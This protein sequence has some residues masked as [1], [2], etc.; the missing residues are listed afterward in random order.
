MTERL[1][2]FTPGDLT[3]E[4]RALYDTI[5]GGPRGQGRQV[6]PLTDDE[7]ALAGPFNAMLLH[8]P[9]GSALQALGSAVRYQGVLDDRAREIAILVVARHWRSGFERY[10][11]EAIGA[12]IGLSDT[13]LAALRA[14]EAF[15]DEHDRLVAAT[16][17]A[18]AARG[19]LSDAEFTAARD[20]LGSAAVF[21]LTTLVGYYAMLAMQ[22]RV[23]QVDAPA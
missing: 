1:A 7:G 3:G 14:G 12:S 22:L 2:R 11:H 9:L 10:S 5:T 21:E 13:E 15:G 18:L 23:F 8:P 19:D 6:F 4:Q 16:A 17:A 20:A